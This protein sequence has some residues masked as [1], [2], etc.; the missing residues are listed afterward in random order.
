MTI[1]MRWRVYE[2]VVNADIARMYRQITMNDDDAE[3]Q[4]IVWRE[5]ESD[6]IRDYKLIT[7]TFGTTPAP[8]LAIK[9]IHRLADDEAKNYPVTAS[10]AKGDFYVDDFYSGS[11]SLEGAIKLRTEITEMMRKGGF[12]IRKW[13]AND[14]RILQGMSTDDREV[15][16]ILEI[17]INS[18]VKTLGVQWN[19]KTDCFTYR[20]ANIA[21]SDLI[22]TKRQ[23]LSTTAK[24]CD[25][26][27]WLAP[28]TTLIK[29]L[30]QKLWLYGIEWDQTIPDAVNKIHQKC[31]AEFPLLENLRIPR[32]IGTVS[33]KLFQL[34]G[35][36]DASFAAYSAVIYVRIIG[37]NGKIHVFLLAA[38]TKIASI[39]IQAAV[40][41]G[42]NKAIDELTISKLELSAAV[43]LSKFFKKTNKSLQR[44]DAERFAWSD[45]TVALAWMQNNS[46]KLPRFVE[47]R[48]KTIRA[49]KLPW[50]HVPGEINPADCASSGLTPSELLQ[51][52]LWWKGPA[53]LYESKEK[54]PID[55][56]AT[57]RKTE[58][59]GINTFVTLTKQHDAIEKIFIIHQTTTYSGVLPS[60]HQQL[61]S[62][63]EIDKKIERNVD[64][65]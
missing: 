12:Q 25:P 52:D 54:W 63:Q 39:K 4:R 42:E 51:H 17:D 22:P 32:W 33:K 34:H 10:A 60:F 55:Q 14:E 30:Y 15:E 16:N 57:D 35:F 8:F 28:T 11:D 31:R 43:L 26:I 45:S 23:F 50:R 41:G 21:N 36:C 9:T 18:T 20:T 49:E 64:G 59:V 40:D 3:Y 44:D 13:I 27:G 2:F 5:N 19:P 7:V 1:L 65:G 47:H 46:T 38:K 48:V 56:T 58:L 62:K 53:F 6:P 24:I 37:E 29:I 61:Q